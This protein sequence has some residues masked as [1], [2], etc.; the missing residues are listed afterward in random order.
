MQ[1]TV[2]THRTLIRISALEASEDARIFLQGLVTQDMNKVQQ[3]SPQW[4]ALLSPQGK[5]LFDFI[6]WAD[7]G[8]FGDDI[9]IDCQRDIAGDLIKRLML[10]RLR[11]KLSIEREELLCVHWALDAADKPKDPR[12]DTLGHRWLARFVEGD[13]G[14]DD[15]F[16]NH[17]LSLGV[18]EGTGELGSDKILWLECNAIELNGV[19]F[20]KG[21]YIGQENSARMHYRNKINRRIVCVP[22]ENANIKRQIT[23]ADNLSIEHRR[24]DD[25]EGVGL[26]NWLAKALET[27]KA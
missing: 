21:C 12:L 1:N 15:I 27:T 6:L 4:G 22:I 20:D 24:I 17:R 2:F 11:R 7:I 13:D 8:K 9:L 14:I 16:K 26:P 10:Y 23:I 25:L 3:D 19:S 5:C 18:C